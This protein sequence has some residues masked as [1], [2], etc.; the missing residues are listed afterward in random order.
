MDIL[1]E[2]ICISAH[3]SSVTRLR[4]EKVTTKVVEQ[5]DTHFISHVL[6]RKAYSFIHE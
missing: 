6:S 2:N 4:R 3:I 1:Y 5:S